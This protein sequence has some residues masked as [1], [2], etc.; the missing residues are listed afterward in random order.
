MMA[1]TWQT[2]MCRKL[3]LIQENHS[4]LYEL[5]LVIPVLA[6]INQQSLQEAYNITSSAT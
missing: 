3:F 1:R 6:F 4:K 5:Q 2:R